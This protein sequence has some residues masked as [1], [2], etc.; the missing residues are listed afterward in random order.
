[1]TTHRVPACVVSLGTVLDCTIAHR[2]FRAFVDEWHGFQLLTDADAFAR[3]E[4]RAR[5]FFVRGRLQQTQKEPEKGTEAYRRWHKRD[6]DK[7]GELTWAPASFPQGR[8]L[9]LGYRSDKWHRRGKSV[10]YTH[11]FLEDQGRAPLVYTNTRTLEGASTIVVVGG[12]MRITEG[13]IA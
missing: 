6:A 7:V 8:L 12:S 11:D 4:G 1:M 3:A 10:D 13:G 9:V 5:L 2:D